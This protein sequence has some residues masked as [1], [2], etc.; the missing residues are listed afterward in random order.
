MS[1]D[2]EI[3]GLVFLA[4]YLFLAPASS[5][6]CAVPLGVIYGALAGWRVRRNALLLIAIPALLAAL[7]VTLLACGLPL[8]SF[9][10]E[11]G[12]A[13][14]EL[15]PV[16][17]GML[18]TF[19]VALVVWILPI[20]A[21][22]SVSRVF[23]TRG[24]KP[25]VV[26]LAAALLLAALMMVAFWAMYSLLASSL[27]SPRQI[28]EEPIIPGISIFG[29][30]LALSCI[31]FGPIVRFVGRNQPRANEPDPL[32]PLDPLTNS[33]TSPNRLSTNQRTVIASLA[34]AIVVVFGCI[35]VYFFNYFNDRPQSLTP[36]PHPLAPTWT[37]TWVPPT[38]TYQGP[39]AALTPHVPTPTNTLVV[40]QTPTTTPRS[41]PP[42]PTAQMAPE[43]LEL[44]D[45]VETDEERLMVEFLMR[46]YE[47]T[48]GLLEESPNVG[49]GKY[50]V[51]ADAYLAGLD[52]PPYDC[53]YGIRPNPHWTVL[54]GELVSEEVFSYG[55]E[56]RELDSANR[57]FSIIDR[58][59]D[60]WHDWQ[61]YADRVL[62]AALNAR[63]A[64]NQPR[65]AELMA[66]AHTMWD[67]HCLR[68]KSYYVYLET[69]GRATC[70]TYKTALYYHLTGDHAALDIVLGLLERNPASEHF[71]G[72]YTH[73]GED[74]K[75][76]PW[77]DA[78]SETT[79]VVLLTIRR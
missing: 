62:L 74:G 24:S 4:V 66:I 69:D 64:G 35:G 32:L 41:C 9:A 16:V 68:D 10:G 22:V 63:Q 45:S 36:S 61:E 76:F 7:V 31:F 38:P 1:P 70:E 57:V 14:N 20:G 34:G 52:T 55:V 60:V 77:I 5:V 43:L 26:T 39:A 3:M 2:D 19:T 30:T 17:G 73:Y 47:P 8:W 72:I 23:A 50:F 48:L 33:A 71:G 6:L 75:S 46:R 59:D 27:F 51:H 44:R 58:P 29:T 25:T 56:E 49:K 42:A 54:H 78:N 28:V 40:P 13:R 18:I 67:G 53:R 65:E 37:P 12:L 11:E 21:A 15:I 79:A